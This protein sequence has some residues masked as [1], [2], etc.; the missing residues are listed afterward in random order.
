MKGYSW[1]KPARWLYIGPLSLQTSDIARFSIIIF[2][3]YYADKKR[4]SL[5]EFQTGLLPALFVLIIIM[6]L[7]IIQPDY[8]T[9]LMIGVIG[10]I[11]LFIGGAEIS[12]L[13]L[14]GACALLVGI[15]ILISR[16]YRLERLLD[17]LGVGNNADIGYQAKQSL[18]SLGNGGWLGVGLGNSIEK[19]H[20]LPTPH[21]DFIFAIIGEEL[22]LVLGTIPVL[23]LFILIFLRGL[24]IAKK[25]TDHFGVFLS[26]GIAFNLVLYAFVNAAVVTG[27]LPVTGLPMPMVSYGGSGMVVNMAMMGILLNISQSRRSVVGSR[28]WSPIFHG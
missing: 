14:S 10:F 3:A 20:F 7:I 6:A 24:K 23:T 16:S 15:P 18:N 13:A 8:S 9:A 11:I 19:N 22:G 4:E 1:Y 27:I 28:S 26:L 25:C 17:F 12:H 5:K 21:T 2:M